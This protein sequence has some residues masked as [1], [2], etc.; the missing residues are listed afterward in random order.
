MP[1]KTRI[2]APDALHHVIGRGIARN[3]IFLSDA[4]REDFLDRL[5]AILSDTKTTCYAWALIPNHF[6]LLLRTGSVPL[7]SV[8]RR[9]LTGYAVHF[10]LRHHRCGHL[11]QNRYKSILCEED[12]YL[13]ELLR[14]IHLN[15]LRAGL[16][17]DY[18]GLCRY[19][20]GGHSMILGKGSREWQDTEY[21]LG[22]FAESRAMARRRYRRFVKEGIE[23]G[24]RPELIG[25][26]LLRSQGGWTG[27]RALREA[28]TYQKGDERILG[29]G[30]FVAQ[31]LAD[32]QEK[33]ERKYRLAASGYT[34][35]RL[36]E[37][38]AELLDMPSQEIL[39]PGKGRKKVEARSLLCY[40]AHTELGITQTQLAR[41]LPLNQPAISNAVRRGAHL[42][43]ER[44]YS[45]EP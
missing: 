14:Y 17:E 12:P 23:Q 13:L 9:L 16:V 35:D 21:V 24:K 29:Q 15:P 3:T 19:P 32:A 31:V 39:E 44:Q 40:W 43:R 18:E 30:D 8:M 26:G 2:D 10:N 42:A 27:V 6:H 28:G 36:I 20:Y 11:F 37:R 7:S 33:F 22:L 38:V 1:R 45:I 41:R 5:G 25:G 4:D 34:L